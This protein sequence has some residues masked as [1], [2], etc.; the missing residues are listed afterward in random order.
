MARSAQP[1]VLALVDLNGFSSFNRRRGYAAG[2]RVLATWAR[3]LRKRLRRNDLIGRVDGDAFVLVLP[4]TGLEAAQ[5]LLDSLSLAF[6]ELALGDGDAAERLS[7]SMRLCE[8]DPR[9][10]A[11]EQLT[12]LET[13]V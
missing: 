8:A 12:T 9:L 1:L 13:D 10:P 4:D 7:F 5:A 3:F 11:A 2:D 6:S